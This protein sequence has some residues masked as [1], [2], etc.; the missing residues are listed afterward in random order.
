M[1]GDEYN[2][3]ALSVSKPG[4]HLQPVEIGQVQIKDDAGNLIGFRIRYILGRRSK[5]ADTNRV[6]GEE[7]RQILDLP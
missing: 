5:G 6:R 1:R 4:L 2:R 3:W 7:V